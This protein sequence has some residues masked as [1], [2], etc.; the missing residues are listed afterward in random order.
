LQVPGCYIKI[1]VNTVGRMLSEAERAYIAGLFDADGAI[2]AMIEKHNEKKYGFRVRVVLK[3]TQSKEPVLNW[4]KDKL[5]TGY[6]GKNRSTY[7]FVVKDQKECF[8]VLEL[9]QEF[10]VG[11]TKQAKIAKEIL[12]HK[13]TTRN[14]LIRK[15]Q[16]ADA[17]SSFNVRSKNRRKNF[18]TKIK[19]S[20][21]RND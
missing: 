21:P 7:D 6:I 10:L 5:K 16:L 4:L 14:E 18:A 15:A 11:K 19:E 13:V 1:K 9:I 3:V 20:I 17:L 2:M 8:R 12:E